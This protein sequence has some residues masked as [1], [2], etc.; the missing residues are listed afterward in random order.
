MTAPRAWLALLA[1]LILIGGGIYWGFE[2]RLPNR[3]EGQAILVNDVGLF[4]V[5][6]QS[7]GRVS[8][9]YVRIGDAIH[10]GQIIARIDQPELV[11]QV[12][13]KR[14]RIADVRD[15]Q[16]QSHAQVQRELR[17]KGELFTQQRVNFQQTL[18][19]TSKR[20]QWYRSKL[21]DQ[22][23]LHKRGLISKQD[24]QKTRLELDNLAEKLNQIGSELKQLAV[25]RLALAQEKT[26]A[27]KASQLE[28]N[29]LRRELDALQEQLSLGS[30]IY[31]PNAGRVTELLV[32]AGQLVSPN[33]SLLRLELLDNERVGGEMSVVAYI[34]LAQGK[35]VKRGMI[36]EIAPSTVK[37]EEYGYMIGLVTKVSRY[38]VT[39]QAIKRELGSDSLVEQV[40]GLSATV[41]VQ[42]HLVHDWRT[43]SGW[44]W[45]SPDGPPHKVNVGTP[46]AVRIITE[47]K[48]PISLVI[49][50]I[51]AWLFG[52]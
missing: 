45:S 35:A 50:K 49:P 22:I 21:A 3:V 44:K 39:T 37:R 14:S 2:G 9:L 24:L 52:S 17:L 47:Q 26:T 27:S 19:A 36:A 48:R 40:G 38:A 6:S 20:Q 29:Q 46:C 33:T 43:V 31:S 25:K 13:R 5:E 1:I 30:R 42:I 28:L 51:K 7:S 11:E 12:Q 32:K 4:N 34:P 10:T 16:K 18:D 41:K 23:K 8:E 15:K